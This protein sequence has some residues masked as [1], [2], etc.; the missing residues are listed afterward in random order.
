MTRLDKATNRII[1][2]A[3]AKTR[4]I[5][6]WRRIASSTSVTFLASGSPQAFA[7]SPGEVPEFGS[8]PGDLQMFKYSGWPSALG[9]HWL[10]SCMGVPRR[11]VLA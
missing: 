6:R 4:S 3:R 9:F 1:T 11:P 2:P 8:N 10:S 5:G 7:A